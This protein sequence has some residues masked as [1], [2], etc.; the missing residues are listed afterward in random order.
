M[1]RR[2]PRSTLFPY[3]TLFRSGGH[4]Q[5]ESVLR[6]TGVSLGDRNDKWDGQID[7]TP[8]SELRLRARGLASRTNDSGR[9]VSPTTG[10]EADLTVAQDAPGPVI[11]ATVVEHSEQVTGDT[12]APKRA[13]KK[14]AEEIG[15]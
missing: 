13:A 12:P 3:T 14:T 10:A 9:F 1:I 6:V 11:K 15:R 2:P 7:L 5:I 4:R 8:R